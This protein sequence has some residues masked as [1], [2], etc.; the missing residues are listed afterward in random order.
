[1]NLKRGVPQAIVMVALLASSWAVAEEVMITPNLASVDVTH[2]GKP[3]TVKRNQDRNNTVNSYYAFTSRRCPP[4][5]IQ[6]MTVAPGVETVGELEV[7]DYLK[8]SSS[9]DASVLVVDTRT[10]QWPKRGIIPGAAN[11]PWTALSKGSS[12][13][14]RDVILIEKFGASPAGGGWD[15]SEAKTLVLYCNGMWC[16]QSSSAIDA[17]LGIGYP[18]EKLKWYRGGM[19]NWENLGLTTVTQE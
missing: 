2:Q 16:S 15:F 4:F 14:E 1:M 17:L 9:G 6:P 19:Q 18:A 10:A 12:K 11:I 8:S 5:C 13:S 3:I 7:L